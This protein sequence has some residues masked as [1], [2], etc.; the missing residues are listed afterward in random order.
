MAHLR[1]RM[2]SSNR[3]MFC[4]PINLTAK[5]QRT[6]SE[7]NCL[8]NFDSLSAVIDGGEGWGEVVQFFK[9]PHPDPLPALAGRGKVLFQCSCFEKRHPKGSIY[10]WFYR[11]AF[12]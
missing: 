5:T 1:T 3:S 4:R 12:F 11:F 7:N 8:T 9:S 6:P 2:W 10:G